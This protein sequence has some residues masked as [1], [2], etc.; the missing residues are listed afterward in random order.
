VIKMSETKSKKEEKTEV[1]L[2]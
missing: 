1:G 2:T